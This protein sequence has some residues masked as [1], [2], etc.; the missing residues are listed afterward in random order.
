[1]NEKE[2]VK[3]KEEERKEIEELIDYLIIEGVEIEELIDSL[4]EAEDI[5]EQTFSKGDFIPTETLGI[6]L[7]IQKREEERT[8]R[9]V[10]ALDEIG[11]TLKD[12]RDRGIHALR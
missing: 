10:K 4:V 8:D 1:M 3:N 7:Y 6:L 5:G 9:I 12:I 2:D 11:E